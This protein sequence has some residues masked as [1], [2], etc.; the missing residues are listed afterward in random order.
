[1][2]GACRYVMCDVSHLLSTAEGLFSLSVGIKKI[3]QKHR[4]EFLYPNDAEKVMTESLLEFK[5]IPT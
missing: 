5:M 4:S 2:N 1:M 3:D